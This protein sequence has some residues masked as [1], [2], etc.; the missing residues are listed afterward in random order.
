MKTESADK[1]FVDLDAWPL[2][3]A[4]AA[5]WQGQA[6]AVAA[7]RPALPAIAAA[8]EAAAEA[9][10]ARGRLV[11][12][13]AGTSGRVAVQDGSELPPTFDWPQRR[14]VFAIAG[15]PRA[16]LR[17]VE[18]AEDD[19]AAGARTVR[20]L[21]VKAGDVVIGV[22]ASG[23]TPFTVAALR[24]ARRN[25]AVTIG[26]AS[27]PDTPLLAAAAF[28]ILVETGSEAIAGSTRMKAGTAQ[29]IVLNLLS[30]GIML[31]LGR[32]YRGLM[33]NMRPANAKLRRRAE[34]MVAKLGRCTPQ[35]AASA[36]EAARGDI[37]L[38]VLLRAGVGLAKARALLK[39]H[40]GHL[41][42]ALAEIGADS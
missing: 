11:Y 34:A 15:G 41:R 3:D 22:A 39:R 42:A 8:V 35:D 21:R 9:L 32:V 36:L 40:D 5:M 4:L 30:T 37:K 19:A 7:I 6:R 31:R 29:K 28:P 1:R 38:A 23:T 16:F 2:A 18:G 17:S 12:V 10:G 27:N 24:A 25:K 33:V 26:L 13:G 14:V 20:R